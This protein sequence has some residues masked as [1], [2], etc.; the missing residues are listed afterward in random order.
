MQLENVIKKK[1]LATPI[2]IWGYGWGMKCAYLERLSMTTKV[3]HYHLTYMVRPSTKSIEISSQ[4][5]CGIGSGC[6]NPV[7]LVWSV[8]WC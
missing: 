7:G 3:E 1:N 5:C 8:L 6:N 4:I 2:A